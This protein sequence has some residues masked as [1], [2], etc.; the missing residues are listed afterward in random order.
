[1]P[2]IELEDF[3]RDAIQSQFGASDQVYS[4]PMMG[5]KAVLT[6]FLCEVLAR[7]RHCL[8]Y[9]PLRCFDNP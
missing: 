9:V 2:Q 3:Y 5:I 6:L 1:V 7:F 4:S 8:R